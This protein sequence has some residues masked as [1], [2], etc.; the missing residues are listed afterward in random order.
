VNQNT[1][2]IM[3]YTLENTI[4]SYFVGTLTCERYSRW[5]KFDSFGGASLKVTVFSNYDQFVKEVT[6]TVEVVR[7][8]GWEIE[9][10]LMSAYIKLEQLPKC[11]TAMSNS[12]HD[13]EQACKQVM[14]A[15][16]LSV[17]VINTYDSW[18]AW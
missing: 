17:E 8:S 1:L 15:L 4:D 14:D 3:S 7:E 5:L 6:K 11:L 9:R 2:D 12:S 13:I 18:G 10:S 16:P